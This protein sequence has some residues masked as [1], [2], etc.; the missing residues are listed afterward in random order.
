M[1]LLGSHGIRIIQILWLCIRY[2]IAHSST[3]YKGETR[4][5]TKKPPLTLIEY[6][7]VELILLTKT[8]IASSLWGQRHP[9]RVKQSPKLTFWEN[10][11]GNMCFPTKGTRFSWT[12][13][14]DPWTIQDAYWKDQT[15]LLAGLRGKIKRYLSQVSFV[16][17][18]AA[19][20]LL[21]ETMKLLKTQKHID[22]NRAKVLSLKDM[23]KDIYSWHAS[24]VRN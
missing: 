15:Q 21:K 19:L 13:E 9:V 8:S 1:P 10:A 12:I 17:D 16:G 18:S 2:L 6:R 11:L 20:K 5:W 3:I 7:L 22:N 4:P 24:S 14:L 23:L